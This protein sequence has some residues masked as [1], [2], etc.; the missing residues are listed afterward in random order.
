MF[1][2][3]PIAKLASTSLQLSAGV[4]ASVAFDLKILQNFMQDVENKLKAVEHVKRDLGHLVAK[5]DSIS[6]NE[7]IPHVTNART[8]L[9][10]A[11]QADS[12]KLMLYALGHA[13]HDLRSMG[14]SPVS[15]SLNQIEFV[16]KADPEIINTVQPEISVLRETIRTVED[17]GFLQTVDYAPSKMKRTTPVLLFTILG[18]AHTVKLLAKAS[19]TKTTSVKKLLSHVLQEMRAE[20]W[21]LG[22]RLNSN[23]QQMVMGLLTKARQEVLT[24]FES[25]V[26]EIGR[27]LRQ[28]W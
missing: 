1:K 15:F 28:L 24:E 25:M 9:I 12:P 20:G 18:M 16:P 11:I 14:E 13:L 8:W 4:G 27:K 7:H 10:K 26:V 21:T 2:N 6:S 17:G 3:S 22:Q 23:Q 5:L 19:N